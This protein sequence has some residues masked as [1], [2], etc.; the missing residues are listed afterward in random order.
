MSRSAA[1]VGFWLEILLSSETEQ[2]L[3]LA[4]WSHR[5][6]G[7]FGFASTSS[8]RSR[9]VALS[10]SAAAD[11]PQYLMKSRRVVSI[12]ATLLSGG[13]DSTPRLSKDLSGAVGKT[14]SMESCG[15][16]H[17]DPQ[18]QAD[19]KTLAFASRATPEHGAQQ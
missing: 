7:P 16:T 12:S 17:T 9:S 13:H 8:R 4:P 5:T 2:P 18:N 14:R 15:S 1:V 19:R 10:P 6:V 3:Q 11:M